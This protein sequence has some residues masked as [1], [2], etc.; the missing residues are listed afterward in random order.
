MEIEEV[1][2]LIETGIPNCEVTV[3]GE[4]CNFSVRVV[5][6]AFESLSPVKR[7]R[8]VLDTVAAPLATGELH[9]ISMKVYTPAEWAREQATSGPAS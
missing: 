7:Q 1:C 2:K 9:A 8:L 5:S 4:A 3:F 6:E